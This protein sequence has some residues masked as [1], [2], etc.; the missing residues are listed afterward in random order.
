LKLGLSWVS[1]GRSLSLEDNPSEQQEKTKNQK[2][3]NTKTQ[4][5]QPVSQWA[6]HEVFGEPGLQ[7]P[8]LLPHLTFLTDPGNGDAADFRVGE[9]QQK[10]AVGFCDQGNLCIP[11]ADEPSDQS[12]KAI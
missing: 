7:M 11:L 1:C 9:S 4:K 8:H 2:Q 6:D 10:G 5:N 12:G 3:T